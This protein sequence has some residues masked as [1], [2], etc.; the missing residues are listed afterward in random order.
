VCS[1]FINIITATHWAAGW[2]AVCATG[3]SS[4]KHSSNYTSCD[5]MW[6]QY[7]LHTLPLSL[8][9]NEVEWLARDVWT[10]CTKDETVIRMGNVCRPI[11]ICMC[12]C[13]CVW[14][15]N[16]D[17]C[18]EGIFY[19][20]VIRAFRWRRTT[21]Q[22]QCLPM[23]SVSSVKIFYWSVCLYL[24]TWLVTVVH[25]DG[26]ESTQVLI[27]VDWL[28]DPLIN[29]YWLNTWSHWWSRCHLVMAISGDGYSNQIYLFTVTTD[30][31]DN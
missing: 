16:T 8:L 24:V 28:M 27:S 29:W 4:C 17:V 26:N 15:L 3:N 12:M 18:L 2:R 1:V 19:S 21:E 13:V 6:T 22:F 5:R 11:R 20:I 7:Q 30:L 23:R 31:T 25:H 14:L 10:E 9:K